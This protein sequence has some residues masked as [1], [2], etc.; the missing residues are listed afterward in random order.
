MAYLGEYLGRLRQPPLVP[1]IWP[2]SAADVVRADGLGLGEAHFA[3]L[4]KRKPAPPSYRRK[5]RG[6]AK[7]L[8]SHGFV[9]P[10][11]G[12]SPVTQWANAPAAVSESPRGMYGSGGH[13]TAPNQ[14]RLRRTIMDPDLYRTN[15]DAYE[16][17]ARALLTQTPPDPS[18]FAFPIRLPVKLRRTLPVTGVNIVEHQGYDVDLREGQLHAL[19]RPPKSSIQ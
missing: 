2:G 10:P 18:L 15:M 9:I 3:R 14:R 8:A 16:A 17:L 5:Q 1:A 13:T 7:P 4:L 19:A 12:Q 11:Q 6:L